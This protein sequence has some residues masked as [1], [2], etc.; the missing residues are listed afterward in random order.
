M[1]N[2]SQSFSNEIPKIPSLESNHLLSA[3]LRGIKERNSKEVV[4]LPK[5]S[6]ASSVEKIIQT[7]ELT[8][9]SSSKEVAMGAIAK[10]H[11][12]NSLVQMGSKKGAKSA[13]EAAFAL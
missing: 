5:I 12:Y 11:N 1:S 10:E 9:K 13:E 3:K 2:L 8:D 7:N 6:I 4:L